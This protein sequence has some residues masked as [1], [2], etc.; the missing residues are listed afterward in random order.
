MLNQA[1]GG[2]ERKSLFNKA[3][4]RPFSPSRSPL[5]VSIILPLGPLA[6]LIFF[7]TSRASNIQLKHHGLC[8][9]SIL[10][11]GDRLAG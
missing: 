10:S 8:Q 5:Q 7:S 4:S 1:R 9:F 11:L 3:Q 2:E 6:A